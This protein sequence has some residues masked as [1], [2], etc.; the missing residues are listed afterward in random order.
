MRISDWSSDVCSSDLIAPHL[1]VVVL[2][3]A[4]L[5]PQ[6]PLDRQKAEG[7]GNDEN[8]RREES[9]FLQVLDSP[10]CWG[11]LIEAAGA[12]ARSWVAY[13]PWPV[14]RGRR[15]KEWPDRPD[16]KSTRLNSSH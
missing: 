10:L 14:K 2:H 11:R 1:D 9:A 5:Q 12:P 6:N 3:R 16:R 4:V 7:D 15:R 13:L 8:R